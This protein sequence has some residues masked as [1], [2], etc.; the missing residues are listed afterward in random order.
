MDKST[1]INHTSLLVAMKIIAFCFCEQ[2]LI[3]SLGLLGSCCRPSALTNG[4]LSQFPGN[5][6]FTSVQPFQEI[7]S[8]FL[9]S[10]HRLN[11]FKAVLQAHSLRKVFCVGVPLLETCRQSYHNSYTTSFSFMVLLWIWPSLV[12][13]E[14]LW[15][16]KPGLRLPWKKGGWALE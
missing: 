8:A 15:H 4:D 12:F 6:S 9:I 5:S 1:L 10:G 16:N 13:C 7:C 3:L 2:V 14:V 11:V